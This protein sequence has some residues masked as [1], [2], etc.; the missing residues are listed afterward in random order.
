MS[1]FTMPNPANDPIA[2]AVQFGVAMSLMPKDQTVE[3]FKANAVKSQVLQR[4][5]QY[6]KLLKD[7]KDDWRTTGPEL[8]KSC[9]DDPDHPLYASERQDYLDEVKGWKDAIKTAQSKL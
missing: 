4:I 1:M 8:L 3:D 9:K 7:V 5:E 6:K 2:Q